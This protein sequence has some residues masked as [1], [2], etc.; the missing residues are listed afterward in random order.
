MV[1]ITI[2]GLRFTLPHLQ[3]NLEAVKFLVEVAGVDVNP[4]DRF[5]GTP[6]TDAIRHDFKDIKEYL[7]SKGGKSR[8][9]HDDEIPPKAHWSY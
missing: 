6:L 8:E 3:V 2:Q 4:I 7:L 9:V 1:V 5:G